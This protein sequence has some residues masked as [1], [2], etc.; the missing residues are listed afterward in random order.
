LVPFVKACQALEASYP[1][2]QWYKYGSGCGFVKLF[3]DAILLNCSRHKQLIILQDDCYPAPSAIDA[4]LLSLREI[5]NDPHIFS[6]YGHHFGTPDEGPET[7]AF[8]C[9]GWGSSSEKLQP[10]VTELSCLWGMPEPRAIDW[11]KQN[12][13]PEI[14]ARM[15][16]FPGRSESKLLDR[17]LCHDAAM[18]F[19]IA[20]KGMSNRKTQEH[21]IYNFGIGERCWHFPSLLDFYLKPPFNMITKS[22]LIERFSLQELPGD[23]ELMAGYGLPELQGRFNHIDAEVQTLRHALATSEK[24]RAD[25]LDVINRLDA[26][27]ATS[28]KDRADRLD[29]INRLDAALATSEQHSSD[30]LDVIDPP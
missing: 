21:V 19:L 13:T 22:D 3:I 18:A 10:I 6:V 2:A 24:D 26:A 29:V 1:E 8:Q 4:L 11:F 27:L 30:R 9:W 23:Y 17:R 12:M 25:R 16:V 7:S 15:D 14:R 20:R 28:E 5:E